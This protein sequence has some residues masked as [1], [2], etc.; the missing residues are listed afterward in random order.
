MKL[1]M[2]N[3]SHSALAYLGLLS[4][5]EHVHD[6]L[7]LPE[8]RAFVDAAMAGELAPTVKG[9]PSADLEAYRRALLRRFGSPRPAHRLAQIAEDGSQKIPI[10]VLNPLRERLAAGAPCDGLL[11]IVAAWLTYHERV[12]AGNLPGPLKDPLADRLL[13]AARMPSV[14]DRV[15][16]LQDVFGAALVQDESFLDRLDAWRG[17]LAADAPAE[18]VAG[19][20]QSD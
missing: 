1:R 5:R 6:A 3:A 17:R 16:A 7:A 10:R 18:V 20:G 8:L 9:V 14:R 13:D 11:V 4:G 15:K 12:A 19:L 2:L